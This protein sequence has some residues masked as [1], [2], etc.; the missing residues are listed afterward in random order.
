MP[1]S[2]NRTIQLKIAKEIETIGILKNQKMLNKVLCPTTIV[3]TS[4]LCVAF[5]VFCDL[6][7]TGLLNKV[8]KKEK[9]IPCVSINWYNSKTELVLQHTI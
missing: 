3:T 6:M 2:Y 9:H 8:L 1:Q 4:E 5:M 7:N